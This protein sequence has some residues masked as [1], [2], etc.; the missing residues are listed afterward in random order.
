[1]SVHSLRHTFATHLLEAGAN[2][3]PIQFLLGHKS[4]RTTV[5]YTRVGHVRLAQ[6]VSPLDL[7]NLKED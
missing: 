6:V 1:M 3:K 4:V 2:R 7:P 5:I